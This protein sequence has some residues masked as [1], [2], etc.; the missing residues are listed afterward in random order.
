MADQAKMDAG[1]R[2]LLGLASDVDVQ[3]CHRDQA[4]ARLIKRGGRTPDIC[5][6]EQI[7]DAPAR[8]AVLGFH[9]KETYISETGNAMQRRAGRYAALKVQ[10]AF[11]KAELD[12]KRYRREAPF[13]AGQ[14]DVGREFGELFERCA[15]SGLKLSSIEGGGGGGGSDGVS[16]AQLADMQRLGLLKRRLGSGVAMPIR[17]VRPSKRGVADGRPKRNIS[18]AVLVRMFCVD[19]DSLSAV[20]AA[21]GWS[22][23]GKSRNVLRDALRVALERMRD[24]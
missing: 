5:D 7:P 19:G 18:D 11:D 4:L 21:H 24:G 16:E 3:R 14:V 10:D 1:V 13:T 15:S 8:G 6:R 2:K 12:A 23:Y 22:D 9:P 20:L 17:R